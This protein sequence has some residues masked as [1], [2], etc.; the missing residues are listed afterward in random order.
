MGYFLKCAAPFTQLKSL[1]G[2]Y[3]KHPLDSDRIE[4][5]EN[6]IFHPRSHPALLAI[7]VLN[8]EST[9]GLMAKDGSLS[10]IY[11]IEFP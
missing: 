9:A 5:V 3:L 11:P 6:P 4:P 10:C 8:L 1:D 7:S 2:C